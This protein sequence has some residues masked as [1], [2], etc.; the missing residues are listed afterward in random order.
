MKRSFINEIIANAEEFAQ[1]RGFYLP[2]FAY[3]NPE[4]WRARANE[5]EQIVERGLG[6][7]SYNFV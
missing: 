3:W 4:E 5:V 7:D 1:E 6:W 2:K